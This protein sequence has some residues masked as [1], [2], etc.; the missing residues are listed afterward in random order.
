MPFYIQTPPL[1]P[2]QQF[3]STSTVTSPT[4]Q[5][6]HLL[7]E[8]EEEPIDVVHE[9]EEED[10]EEMKMEID[11]Q[12]QSGLLRR[13]FRPLLTSEMRSGGIHKTSSDSNLRKYSTGYSEQTS[14]FGF[15]R[16]PRPHRPASN[17]PSG[18]SQ[19][20]KIDPLQTVQ[21]F[22]Q[23]HQSLMNSPSVPTCLSKLL[24]ELFA[25][26]EHSILQ[27][28]NFYRS[29]LAMKIALLLKLENKRQ[30]ANNTTGEEEERLLRE[31]GALRST[32]SL[33]LFHVLTSN[34][35]F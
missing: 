17:L 32:S 19:E 24:I 26:S 6:N 27:S 21:Q 13:S 33:V 29:L 8:D 35:V 18:M 9:E 7:A 10:M 4:S 5:N 15:L 3:S 23:M 16:G 34:E 20:V 30:Q 12:N 14:A 11:L 28:V 2:A 25:Y 22:L 31:K 1:T